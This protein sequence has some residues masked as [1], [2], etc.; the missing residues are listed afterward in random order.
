[1]NLVNMNELE[2]VVLRGEPSKYFKQVI[3]KVMLTG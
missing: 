1:M 2:M 3:A